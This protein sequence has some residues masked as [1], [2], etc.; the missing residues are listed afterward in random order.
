MGC[1]GKAQPEA[2]K[3]LAI[4][5]ESERGGQVEA[6]DSVAYDWSGQH[7][8]MSSGLYSGCGDGDQGSPTPLV[9]G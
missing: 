2:K 7:N 1:P 6:V 3:L 9:R 4:E 8:Q 5:A